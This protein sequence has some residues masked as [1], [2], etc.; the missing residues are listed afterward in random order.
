MLSDVE[1][2]LIKGMKKVVF[3]V[4]KDV[5]VNYGGDNGCWGIEAITS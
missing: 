4:T 5:L 2:V 1:L 3:F